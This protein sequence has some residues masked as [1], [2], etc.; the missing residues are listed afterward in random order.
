[1]ETRNRGASRGRAVDCASTQ[2][3]GEPIRTARRPHGAEPR[4]PGVGQTRRAS[5]QEDRHHASGT[6]GH[7][8]HL[9]CDSGGPSRSRL[10]LFRLFKWWVPPQRD[11]RGDDDR[12]AANGTRGLYLSARAQQDATG[13]AVYDFDTGQTDPRSE[14]GC[15]GG[16]AGCVEYFGGTNLSAALEDTDRPCPA[17]ST[18][19]GSDEVSAETVLRGKSAGRADCVST[20][21]CG[22]GG[23]CRRSRPVLSNALPRSRT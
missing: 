23:P 20:E 11:C 5:G 22:G 4:P 8:G 9:R 2:A 12:F 10:A 15:I 3:S 14:C 6:G 21:W 19:Y 16:L 18:C 1:M 13:W 7:A 17:A